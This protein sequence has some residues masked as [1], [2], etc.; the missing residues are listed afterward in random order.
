MR[1]DQSDTE[2]R[3]MEQFELED[4]D[5]EC[6]TFY[7]IKLNK[8]ITKVNYVCSLI[9]YLLTISHIYM[10]DSLQP[11]ILLDHNY[12]HIEKKHEGT[13][14]GVILVIQL[15]VKVTGSLILGHFVDVY[16]RRKMLTIGSLLIFIGCMLVP[17]QK[18]VFP[19]FVFAKMFFALGNTIVLLLP[20]NADYVHDDSK[21][22]ASGISITLSAIGAIVGNIA[23]KIFLIEGVAL[24]NIYY[25]WGVYVIVVFNI[26]SLGLKGGNLYYRIRKSLS[27]VNTSRPVREIFSDAYQTFLQIPW[28][29]IALF[30]QILG[31]ADFYILTVIFAIFIKS[32]FPEDTPDSVSNMFVNNIQTLTLVPALVS[33]LIYG[34]YLDRTKKV[35]NSIY[36]SL[37]GGIIGFS[38][39][40]SV[41]Q[42]T[43]VALKVAGVVLGSTLTGIYTNAQYLGNTYFPQ[44]KRGILLGVM[45]AF[46]YIGYMILAVGGGYLFDVWKRTA[47]FIINV[48]FLVICVIGVFV[49]YKKRIAT[50]A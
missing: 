39:A 47:P 40:I 41:E 37:F 23:L 10:S 31:N 19:G 36:A 20:F 45:G 30:L 4:P 17:S 33:N 12:Y 11:L 8:G 29:M 50:D 2:F 44:E 38:I 21:G 6:E 48:V 49:I 42:P 32:L 34:W 22:K 13:I 3:Q 26:N 16:G 28:L 18:T 25:I 1:E 9:Q 7:T 27:S 24:G 15:V 14:L 35:M 43:D 5:A 46:G